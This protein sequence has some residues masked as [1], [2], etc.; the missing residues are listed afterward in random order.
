MRNYNSTPVHKRDHIKVEHPFRI[1]QIENR[2]RN[3]HGEL[4]GLFVTNIA[5]VS[6]KWNIRPMELAALFGMRT[7]DCRSIHYLPG[8]DVMI[9]TGWSGDARL[10]DP[11]AVDRNYIKILELYDAYSEFNRICRR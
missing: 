5:S 1:S 11:D 7:Q 2:V 9:M 4:P 10:Y 6:R 8:F 3:T